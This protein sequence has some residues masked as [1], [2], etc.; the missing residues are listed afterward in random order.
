MPLLLPFFAWLFGLQVMNERLEHVLHTATGLTGAAYKGMNVLHIAVMAASSIRSSEGAAHC[1]WLVR[2]HPHLLNGR[3]T[4]SFFQPTGECYYGEYPLSFAVCTNQPWIVTLILDEVERQ[5][6]SGPGTGLEGV[7][8]HGNTAL[9]LTVWHDL[10][11]MYEH[12]LFEVDRR[13]RRR[14]LRIA[15]ASVDI[16]KDG[17]LDRAE[18]ETFCE[19]TLGVDAAHIATELA[20]V[21]ADIDTDGDGEV[22]LG[23]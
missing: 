21:F 12:V 20:G 13:R 10:L 7:D 22:R 11:K 1:R 18:V 19:K 17:C 5:G 2:N 16:D 23:Y 3:A 9:H 6:L 15:F 4:G 8:A 14:Q